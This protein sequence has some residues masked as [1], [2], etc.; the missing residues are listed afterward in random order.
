VRAV[1]VALACAVLAAGCGGGSDHSRPAPP[2]D[3]AVISAWIDALNARDYRRAAAYF[4]PGAIVDQGRP[5]RLPD[6]AAAIE[7]NRGL[8]CRGKLTAVEDEGTTSLGTFALIS[9]SGGPGANCDGSA[10]VRFKIEEGRFKVWRQLP[11][12]PAPPGTEAQ[13]PWRAPFPA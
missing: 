11:T 2:S 4:A 13:G 3:R 8:P 12:A 9:G 10:R 6:R 1:A 5:V 7:F